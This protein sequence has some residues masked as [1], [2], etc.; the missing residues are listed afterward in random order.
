[1]RTLLADF[2]Y[3]VVR[4]DDLTQIATRLDA[5]PSRWFKVVRLVSAELR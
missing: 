1:M 3:S 5:K 2:G 4:D